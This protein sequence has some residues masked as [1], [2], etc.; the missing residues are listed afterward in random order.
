M[1]REKSKTSKIIFTH[2]QSTYRWRKSSLSASS[3]GFRLSWLSH[4]SSQ[5]YGLYRTISGVGNFQRHLQSNIQ[6]RLSQA[7]RPIASKGQSSS[8]RWLVNCEAQL[9]R[10]SLPAPSS[11]CLSVSQQS[12]TNR[13]KQ[14]LQAPRAAF[15]LQRLTTQRAEAPL[16]LSTLL[17]GSPQDIGAR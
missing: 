15:D 3:A 8:A 13:Q 4:K 16:I 2:R 17:S 11:K 6:T 9:Q 5:S 1:I 14:H 10:R 12:A 7:Q